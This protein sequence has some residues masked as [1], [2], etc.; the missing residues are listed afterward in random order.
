M[1]TKGAT[2]A[3]SNVS[4]DSSSLQPKTPLSCEGNRGT[5]GTIVKG[6][7]LKGGTLSACLVFDNQGVADANVE[8]EVRSMEAQHSVISFCSHTQMRQQQCMD[9]PGLYVYAL[10]Y[11][12]LS[13]KVSTPLTAL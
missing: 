7:Y 4:G 6:G 11:Q 3:T 1:I 10:K 8:P 9:C 13:H 12:W 5:I 2:C